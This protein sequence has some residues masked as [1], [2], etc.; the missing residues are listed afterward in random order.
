MLRKTCVANSRTGQIYRIFASRNPFPKFVFFI[1]LIFFFA[2]LPLSPA[3][4]FE[5]IVLRVVLNTEEMGDIFMYSADGD[6]L[7]KKADLTN[8]GFQIIEGDAVEMDGETYM[9]L[10]SMKGVAYLLDQENLV[11][12]ITASPE[13]LPKKSVDLMLQKPKDIYY[14]KNNSAFL[15]YGLSHSESD[16]PG[17]GATELDNQLGVRLFD[18]LFLTDTHYKKTRLG[19]SFVR[20]NSSVTHDRRRDLQ[21][22]VIG[23]FTSVSGALGSSMNMGGLS[24]SKV[25]KIDPYLVKYPTLDL[26][27]FASSPS[28]VEVYVDGR[29]VFKDRISPGEFEIRNLSEHGGASLVEIVLKDPY[30]TERRLRYPVYFTRDMLRPGFGEYSYNIG[31]RREK[32]GV[33]SNEYGRMAYMAF[34]DYGFNN[35]LTAGLRLEGDRDLYNAG[36]SASVKLGELGIANLNYAASKSSDPDGSGWAGQARYYYAGREFGGGVNYTKYSEKYRTLATLGTEPKKYSAGAG[37]NIGNAAIGSLSFDY[38]VTEFYDGQSRKNYITAYSRSLFTGGTQFTARYTYTVAAEDSYVVFA[39]INQIL[40]EAVTLNT[41]YEETKYY[42]SEFMQLRKDLPFGEGLGYNANIGRIE[43]SF[44]ERYIINPSAQYKA[45]HAILGADYYGEYKGDESDKHNYR[46]SM[47]GGLMYV[48]STIGLSRP[49]QDGFGLAKVGELKDVDVYVNNLSA[50][51]TN[52]SGKLFIPTLPSYYAMKV[53]IASDDIPLEYAVGDID[54]NVATSYR[55]GAF[56]DFGVKRFHA[57][58]GRL[59]FM[60]GNA[61]EPAEYYDVTASIEGR[62]VSIPVGS[63]GE[64][65]TEDMKTGQSYTFSFTYNKAPILCEI[66][67]PETDETIIDLGDIVCGAGPAEKTVIEEPLET[68][69]AAPAEIAKPAPP[70]GGKAPAPVAYEYIP[71]KGY[72]ALEG[73]VHFNADSA[74]VAGKDEYL[75]KKTIR[76]LKF[77]KELDVEIEGH[78]DP[79]G[80]EEHNMEL[81]RQRAVAVRDYLV[82]H[83]IDKRRITGLMSFGESMPVCAEGGGVCRKMNQRAVVRLILG[84]K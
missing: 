35:Y 42:E 76:I 81:G 80:S 34:H 72:I 28:E 73:I 77:N 22:I 51:K 60:V 50:G 19:E 82:K 78:S 61:L 14:A 54:R 46:L 84:E 75:L 65:Y 59:M 67:V 66:A 47:S 55:G 12:E 30:G 2:L 26:S 6:F 74:R 79:A 23:D 58:T 5:S 4:A 64:F 10:V 44:K 71:F 57:V 43:E 3:S 18:M 49:V 21:R 45:K 56:V 24:F 39:G 40:G 27:A 36:A 15:N 69:S 31:M 41:S 7:I 52:S 17:S 53:S 13:L 68:G 11:L 83:G 9:S 20:L 38:N 37:V 29:R 8:M 25:Y 32:F 1:H 16:A 70:V 33:K 63:G 48:A 62:E